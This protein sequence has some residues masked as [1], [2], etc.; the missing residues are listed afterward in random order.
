MSTKSM[1][2]IGG[3]RAAAS[4][5]GFT[6]R[7]SGLDLPSLVQMCATNAVTG[8]LRI[9]KD[10]DTAEVYF[11]SGNIVHA[12]CGGLN[13]VAGFNEILRW[14]SGQIDLEPDK[15]PSFE[16]INKPCDALLIDALAKHE[17]QIAGLDGSRSDTFLPPRAPARFTLNR[18]YSDAMAWEEIRNCLIF[19]T[20]ENQIIRPTQAVPKIQQWKAIFEKMVRDAKQM[21]LSKE[22]VK[23]FMFFIKLDNAN[24]LLI[25]HE[26]FVMAFEINR[27][28][29]MS[30]IYRRVK[31]ICAQDI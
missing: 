19:S 3:L 23:P 20:R 22:G 11:K 18:V 6:G 10:D 16:S 26:E 7:L 5:G 24:W 9:R 4:A 8:V 28:A 29:D 21:P 13:G 1:P 31:R 14:Q 2:D 12:D 25:P 30:R 27:G 15:G 17:D